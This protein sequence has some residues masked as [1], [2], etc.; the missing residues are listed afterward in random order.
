MRS[1]DITGPKSS[2]TL[3][4]I[5]AAVIVFALV[6]G[7]HDYLPVHPPSYLL[8]AEDKIKP[9]YEVARM[10]KTGHIGTLSISGY[11]E[12]PPVL[13]ARFFPQVEF[14]GS[15]IKSNTNLQLWSDLPPPIYPD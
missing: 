10:H 13:I 3:F 12:G 1:V 6:V 2:R 15:N 9:Q 8:L 14:T 5:L 4:T 11:P 7:F